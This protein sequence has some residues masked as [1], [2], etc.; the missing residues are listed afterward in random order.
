MSE[1]SLEQR[2]YKI[3]FQHPEKNWPG[4]PDEA[5]APLFDVDIPTF[6]RVKETF[7]VSARAA[8]VDLLRDP[9]IAMGVDRIS[10]S[11]GSTVVGLGDSITDDYQSS[12]E[13]LRHLLDLRRTSRSHSGCECWHLW[14]HNRADDQP[15]S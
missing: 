5:I 3:Q 13:I 14:R 7:A 12:L 2:S 10:F 8:A 9:A 11:P 1:L 15:F 6:R 4:L